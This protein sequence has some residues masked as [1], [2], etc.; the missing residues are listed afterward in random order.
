MG[1]PV[2]IAW[3]KRA[4]TA[5]F[6]SPHGVGVSADGRIAVAEAEGHTLRVLTQ[7][8]GMAGGY[9]VTTL[10]GKPAN[11]QPAFYKQVIVPL[12]FAILAGT[13]S[14]SSM[15]HPASSMASA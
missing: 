9:E 14:N 12:G 10:A 11:V 1:L 5:R 8:A 2:A 7:R 3:S 6:S 13:A 15:K 4:T